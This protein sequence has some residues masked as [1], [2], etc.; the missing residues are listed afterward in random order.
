MLNPRCT[1]LSG[2]HSSDGTVVIREE[3]MTEDEVRFQN[4]DLHCS[5]CRAVYEYT[6]YGDECHDVSAEKEEADGG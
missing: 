3:G 2:A 6:F 4:V 1:S 5:E